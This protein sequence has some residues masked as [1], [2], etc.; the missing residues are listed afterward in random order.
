M[1]NFCAVTACNQPKVK[2]KDAVTKL[3][4]KYRFSGDLTVMVDDSGCLQIWGED[5][6]S[7]YSPENPD[8]DHVDYDVPDYDDD[9][10]EEFLEELAPLLD[11]GK[12][13]RLIIQSIGNEKC[14]FPLFGFEWIID[15]TSRE[16]RSLSSQ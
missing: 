14:R 3:I 15:G 9:V 2:V 11:L 6:F 1:A 8:P 4:E 5:T 13:G 7:A 16:W 10:T 12:G